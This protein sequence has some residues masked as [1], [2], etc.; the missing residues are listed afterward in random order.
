VL[1]SA[2]IS[3]LILICIDIPTARCTHRCS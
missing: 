3:V 2:C 1:I